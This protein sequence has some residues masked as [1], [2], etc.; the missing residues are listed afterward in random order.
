MKV[1]KQ[2][3]EYTIFKRADD[4]YA[5]QGNNR[6]FINGDEKVAILIKEDLRKAP[7][8]KPEPA[9]EEAEGQDE[10]AAE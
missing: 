7:E 5:V 9:A 6:K 10:A 2:T 3:A 1:V 4:R 8:P